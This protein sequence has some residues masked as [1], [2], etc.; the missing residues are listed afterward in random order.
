VLVLLSLIPAWLVLNQAEEQVGSRL[1]AG[2]GSSK[3]SVT[4]TV[5]AASMAADQA[6]D[7]LEAGILDLL[8]GYQGTYSVTVRELTEWGVDVSIDGDEQKEPAS[9]IKLFIA[10][11]VLQ[12]YDEGEVSLNESVGYGQ[13]V[14]SCM[15]D[16]IEQSDN[17]CSVYLRELVGDERINAMWQ[18]AGYTG[19]EVL[20][21][22]DD[23]YVGKV[24]T[25]DDQA[26][27]L[28]R[29]EAG[30]ALSA[31]S[32]ELLLDHMRDQVWRERIPA[33]LPDEAE[34]ADKPGWLETETGWT[35][36]D[37]A[38]VWGTDTV[39]VLT[40]LGSDD[41]LESEIA[42]LSAYVYASLNQ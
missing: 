22:A 40:V 18:A 20:L 28:E 6:S 12:L 23:E 19:T 10:W 31:D 34:V 4:P 35:E 33:G 29:L 38:I 13:T 14:S 27:L 26:L 41:A 1:S 42:D 15:A 21:D 2:L 32:T 7:E 39:Y 9:T 11:A 25:T 8:A 5:N 24:T 17:D 30:T 3:P 16:M 36:S 37:A